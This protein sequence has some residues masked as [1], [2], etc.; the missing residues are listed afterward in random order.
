MLNSNIGSRFNRGIYNSPVHAQV[1]VLTTAELPHSC[2]QQVLSGVDVPVMDRAALRA[3]PLSDIK[4]QFIQ[5]VLALRAGFAGRKETIQDNQSTAIPLALVFQL[6]A[7]FSPARI[8]DMPSQ[9]GVLNHVFNCQVLDTDYLI[10]SDKFR[11]QL[12]R[13]ILALISNLGVR[14]S[15]PKLLKIA[16]VA[17]FNAASQGALLLLQISKPSGEPP[18]VVYLVSIAQCRKMRQA[19]VNAN[20]TT[21]NRHQFDFNIDTKGY[22]ISPIRFALECGCFW[23]LR[24]KLFGQLNNAK[25]RDFAFSTGPASWGYVS[26]SETFALAPSFKFWKSWVFS[27]FNTAEEMS[28][29]RILISETFGKTGS[30][31]ISQPR[32]PLKLL[33]LGQPL[34]NVN[35]VEILLPAVVRLRSGFKRVIPNPS[36]RTKPMIKPA[37]LCASWISPDFVGTHNSRHGVILSERTKS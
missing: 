6:S 18:G 31:A 11:S 14:L 28:K 15:N 27:G 8:G 35:A 37:N 34:I 1:A 24:R 23:V 9:P 30:R 5:L 21:Y 16:A 2:G 25:F 22:E 7:D 33:K 32:K 17:A 19:E 10:L 20:S 3:R 26:K 12:M 29:R 36:R 13:C 4:P